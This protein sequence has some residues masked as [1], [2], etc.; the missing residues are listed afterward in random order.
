MSKL[1]DMRLATKAKC[2]LCLLWDVTTHD[3]FPFTWLP[4]FSCPLYTFFSCLDVLNQV[5][6]RLGFIFLLPV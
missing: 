4:T 5:N 6:E 2:E 3:M 1:T